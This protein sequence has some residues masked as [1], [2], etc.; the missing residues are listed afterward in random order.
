[1]SRGQPR[2][3]RV[4]CRGKNE[5]EIEDEI[6]IDGSGLVASPSLGS[7][8]VARGSEL[9]ELLEDGMMCRKAVWLI[10][11]LMGLVW[12]GGVGVAWWVGTRKLRLSVAA[13]GP[14]VVR[15][16]G[17]HGT[18]G[19][20]GRPVSDHASRVTRQEEGEEVWAEGG[21]TGRECAVRD[22]WQS[23]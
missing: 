9:L 15:G 17:T 21:S 8:L 20:G 5:I 7:K 14:G 10:A 11:A 18:D 2:G 1:M 23:T 12:L 3:S 13:G 19:T 22:R 4:G 6:E 16:D